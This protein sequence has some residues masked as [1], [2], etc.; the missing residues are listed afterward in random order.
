MII[1][2]TTTEITKPSLRFIFTNEFGDQTDISK[3]LRGSGIEDVFDAIREALAGCGFGKETI[4]QW[5]PE[6]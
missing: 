2:G 6:E 3:D 4:D 1:P 5:F